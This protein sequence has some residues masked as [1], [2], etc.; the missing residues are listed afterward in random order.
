MTNKPKWVLAKIKEKLK[1]ILLNNP[2]KSL[3]DIS[4]ASLGL[5]FKPDID[6]LRG[7]PAL[8]VLRNY[9]I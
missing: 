8:N 3:N 9:V 7:S 2:D 6:D 4:V 5:A 1:N